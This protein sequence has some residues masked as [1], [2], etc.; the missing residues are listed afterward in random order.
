MGLICSLFTIKFKIVEGTS[1]DGV[2][3]VLATSPGYLNKKMTLLHKAKSDSRRVGDHAR[4]KDLKK[5]FLSYWAENNNYGDR[6]RV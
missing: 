1:V 3:I 6:D 5:K 4:A 2:E